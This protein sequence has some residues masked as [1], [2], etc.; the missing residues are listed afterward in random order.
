MR[1]YW[2]HPTSQRG[3]SGPEDSTLEK[4]RSHGKGSFDPVSMHHI[5][6]HPPLFLSIFHAKRMLLLGFE[7][8]HMRRLSFRHTLFHSLWLLFSYFSTTINSHPRL[9]H[10][11][12]AWFSVSYLVQFRLPDIFQPPVHNSRLLFT[13]SQALRE[14]AEAKERELAELAA[15]R[16]REMDIRRVEREFELK[17]RLDRV[18]EISKVRLYQR[19]S[20]LERIMDDYERT[21]QMMRERQTLMRVRK[22]TNMAASMQ[23]QQLSQAMEQLRNARS[24]ERLAGPNGTVSVDSLIRRPATARV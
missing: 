3:T 13:R 9:S 8:R 14:R 6:L 24:L 11:V 16:K 15:S 5:P 1:C 7:L 19:Q 2:P 12:H 17:R 4:P 21:R 23:R 18:D 10:G 22:D 20:L